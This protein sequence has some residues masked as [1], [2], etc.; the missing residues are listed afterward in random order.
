MAAAKKLNKDALPQEPRLK[1][2]RAGNP[3]GALEGDEGQVFDSTGML[4]IPYLVLTLL[5]VAIGLLMM[6]SASYARA[7]HDTGNAAYYFVRQAGFAAFGIVVML[8]VSRLNYFIFHRLS[9]LALAVSL[10]LLLMVPFVGVKANGARRWIVILGQNFQPSEIAKIAVVLSFASMMSVWKDKMDTFQYGVLPYALVLGVMAVLLYLEPHM[11]ATVIILALGATMMFLGGTKARWFGVGLL[12]GV[13][14][15]FVYLSSKGYTGDRITAW[16]H[17]E[18]DAQDT[19]YQIIQ[20]RYA[21]GSGGFLGLGFGH[22]RQ[23]YLYLPEEHNDYIFA[24]VCEELGFIGAAGIILLFV[25]LIL[26]G[27]W[28]ALHARDRFGTLVAAGLT[29]LLALQVFLNMAVVSNL[30]PSTGISL[31]FFSYGGTALV[32]QLAEMGI[33]LSISRWCT[34]K[35]VR[36]A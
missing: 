2:N 12:M 17:P 36:I 27:Y 13:V 26:R 22:S 31:P 29:T 23:K 24:I 10:V 28:I 16:L 34:N 15:V 9:M 18:N 8:V 14:F 25:L 1:T 33:V 6:F 20:S 7:L 30:L 4:D 35:E 32:I 19:G 21:I 3:I 11:S 5:L